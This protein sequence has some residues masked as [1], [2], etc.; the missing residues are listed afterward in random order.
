MGARPVATLLSVALPRDAA[1]GWALEFMEGYRALS[2][3]YGTPLVG[4][5]TT[6]SESGITINVTAI[7]RCP[8]THLKRRRDALPGTGFCRREPGRLGN[9]PAGDPCGGSRHAAGSRAPQPGAAGR[10]GRLARHP[11]GGA[12]NDGPFGRSGLGSGAHPRPFA[13]GGAEIEPGTDSGRRG[14][15]PADGGLRRRGLQTAF[16]GG[17][18]V[19]GTACRGVPSAIRGIRSTRSGASPAARG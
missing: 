16:H 8:L 19:C 10:R 11:S 2:A 17:I 1:E 4:G 5:D 12:R 6:R 3:R 14:V 7:G 15:R 9:G 18:G 13:H